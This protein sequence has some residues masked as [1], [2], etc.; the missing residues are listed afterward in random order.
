MNV[1]YDVASHWQRK[2]SIPEPPAEKAH[3]PSICVE[4]SV[5]WKRD[6]DIAKE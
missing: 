1:K 3:S 2:L 5:V 4:Y 6:T